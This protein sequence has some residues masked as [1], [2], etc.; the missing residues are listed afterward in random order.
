MNRH[1]IVLAAD[2][3][4]TVPY[5]SEVDQAWKERYFKGANKIFQLSL[6]HPVGIMIYG[7]A[8]LHE[9]P[10]EVIVKDFRA[11][12]G[13]KSFNDVAAYADEFFTFI[14]NHT[15]LFPADYQSKIF[16][17]ETDKVAFRH[18]MDVRG[19]D[20]V[21]KAGAEDEKR[22][23]ALALYDRAV[24]DIEAIPIA[25]PFD[26]GDLDSALG[27]YRADVEVEIQKTC[28]IFDLTWVDAARVADLAIRTLFKRP[29]DL[30]QVTGVV[31]AGYGDHD[32]FPGYHE[33]Q[34]H[35]LLLGKFLAKDVD[36]R[37]V[38]LDTPAQIKAFATTDMVNTFQMGFSP[39]VFSTVR[40]ELRKALDSFAGTLRTELGH[41][42][43]IP[44][45]KEHIEVAV[46]AHTDNWAKAARRA[47]A[48]PLLRVIGSLPVDEMAELAETLVELQSLKEKVTKP[49]ESVG[50]PIDVAVISKADGFIWIKRKHYF[51]PALNPR[52]LARQ[53]RKDA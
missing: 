26:Q 22:A 9:V 36:S 14:R 12:L 8:S 46:K 6:H 25:A 50:G 13:D 35:G 53:S 39:D 16:R 40:E 33:Y 19:D 18:L 20:S 28:I 21:V 15:H 49:T 17:D 51:D 30:M 7:T 5:W 42:G 52:F 37:S 11:R 3:A 4:A 24:A 44:N 29:T 31:V 2:S 48:W 23:A 10:W 38:S 47:H 34:C 45:L 43:E 32:Y 41:A 27:K 1:A